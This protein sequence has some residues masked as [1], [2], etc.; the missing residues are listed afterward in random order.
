M[1]GRFGF[2]AS[3]ELLV[4]ALNR[5]GC[6][7]A[8][9]FA[10]RQ[11]CES[12]KAIAGFVETSGNRGVLEPPLA[13]EGLAPRRNLVGRGSI[14]HLGA[15]GGDLVMQAL[16]CMRQQVAMFVNRAPLDRH[17]VPDRRNGL[18]QSRR[19]VNDE[20]LRPPQATRDE[21]IKNRTPGFGP[22]GALAQTA[23][24]DKH[25]EISVVRHETP[26]RHG[27]ARPGRPDRRLTMDR[28]KSQE[29]DHP[30]APWRSMKCAKAS[31]CCLIRLRVV[32]SLISPVL[33][34]TREATLPT[35][36]SGLFNVNA[37]RK[38]IIL[39]RSY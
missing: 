18:L 30:L 37:S 25:I 26:A 32:S 12:E 28:F 6:P 7:R 31:S 4:E 17:V 10:C 15:V 1:A 9:P 5:V 16:G 2:D 14:D 27:R 13:N 38:H 36:I 8:F 33:S 24:S 39:R 22:S 21:V 23:T 34:S 11:A 29:R 20:E 19:A 35:K 3:L